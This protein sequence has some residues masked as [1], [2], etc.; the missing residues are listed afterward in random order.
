MICAVKDVKTLCATKEGLKIKS[1]HHKYVISTV[2][3]WTKEPP[4]HRVFWWWD[5]N[6]DT[7]VKDKQR[8]WKGWKQGGSKGL[9]RS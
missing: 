9:P 7:A 2:C 8:L 6:V 5:D 3:D 1:R 4:R